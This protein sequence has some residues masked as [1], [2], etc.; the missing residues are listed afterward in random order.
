MLYSAARSNDMNPTLT[1]SHQQI[2][3]YLDCPRRFQLRHLTQLSWP[4]LPYPPDVEAAFS[5]GRLLHRLVERHYLGL[6][7]SR[8]SIIDPVVAAWWDTFRA[9]A[10]APSPGHA[11]PE[12][13]LTVPLG[14]HQ[15]RGRFDLISLDTTGGTPRATIF[16]WK[17]SKPRDAAWLR[18]A[19]QTRLYLALVAE[20]GHALPGTG[21]ERIRPGDISMVYWY[22]ADP[23]RPVTLQY[24]DAWH[25]ENWRGLEMTLAALDNSLHND[26]WPLTEEWSHCRYC[27]FQAYCGRQA[28]GQPAMTDA[29]D[30]EDEDEFGAPVVELE[31]DWL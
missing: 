1:L 16:D 30:I 24:D 23:E 7:V 28:A 5:R 13:S 2:Q 3:D 9:Y 29:G 4:D 12:A 10:P 21:S 14:N 6:D 31:P 27:A 8:E 17:T 26:S 25:A 18:Q 15:L 22:L 19:W 20:G 11:Q